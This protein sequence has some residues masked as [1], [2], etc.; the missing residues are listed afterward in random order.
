M[1]RVRGCELLVRGRVDRKSEGTSGGGVVGR[2]VRRAEERSVD[3][4]A[5]VRRGM[6]GIESARWAEEP[7]ES[8][9]RARGETRRARRIAQGQEE[10]VILHA[11]GRGQKRMLIATTS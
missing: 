3:V 2:H 1:S 9:R 8:W 10:S 6:G 7:L 11:R 5:G 4:G